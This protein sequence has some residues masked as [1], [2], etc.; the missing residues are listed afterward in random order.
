[1]PS[2]MCLPSAVNVP[3]RIELLRSDGK[4]KIHQPGSCFPGVGFLL[5]TSPLTRAKKEDE[6]R[7]PPKNVLTLYPPCS[8]AQALYHG[9]QVRG[10]WPQE[11][12]WTRR[13]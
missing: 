8:A 4:V 3:C 7:K 10:R 13:S 2:A 6:G 5:D 11:G 1:M 12:S 9:Q